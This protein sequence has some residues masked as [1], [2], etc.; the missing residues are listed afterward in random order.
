[1]YLIAKYTIRFRVILLLCYLS[2]FT[3]T[4]SA[5][6]MSRLD[7]LKYQ[8]AALSTHSKGDTNRINLM[9]EVAYEYHKTDPDSGI[10]Y[11]QDALVESEL[12]GWKKGMAMAGNRIGLCYWA[13]SDYPH[14]LEYH[15][16]ALKVAE[17][18]D[19]KQGIATI[20]GNIG[21]AY[22]GQRDYEKALDYHN[23]AMVINE[24]LGNKSGVARNL[25]NI[26]IVYDAKGDFK[27]A[28]KFYLNAMQEYELL[29]D[30]GGVARNLGNIG[31][32]YQS[33][34]M[35]AKALEYLFK[36]LEM[37][38]ELG[39][40]ILMG[41]NL[42]NIG[43]TYLNI[44]KDTSYS[45]KKL[46]PDSLLKHNVAEK[47]EM[48]LLQGIA[49][50]KEID[51]MNSMQELY[52]YLSELQA[53]TGNY[54]ESLSSYKIHSS[55]MNSLFNEENQRK[56]AQLEKNREEDIK[57]K[58]IE[59]LKSQNEVERLKT[60]RRSSI[61]YGLSAV[62]A[63]LGIFTISFFRQSNKRRL[64]NLE[65]QGAYS[66]LKDTQQQLVKSEKMAAFGLMAQRIA[67][68]IQNPLNFVN[69]FSEISNELVL[70]LTDA[71]DETSR[72][73]TAGILKENLDRIL[74]HGKRAETI[75]KEL[76]E[77]IRSGTAHQYFE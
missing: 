39:N 10:R 48:Y 53:L 7:S 9:V 55:Y 58:E 21:L 12:A 76:Q 50:F 23:R 73:E 17:S 60:Q 31:F 52:G 61:N 1:M 54:K 36:A 57:Q 15:F 43:G 67:H 11:G 22:E 68:E 26:G 35:H 30:K 46:L 34:N 14:S 65:L 56:I 70:E 40:K 6:S 13:K 28:L 20:L 74:H 25:G 62:L 63:L 5:Q 45:N 51:D 19:Y 27:N 24:Q 71:A 38:Q 49:I 72:M 44:L 4:V 41:M 69:N 47:S 2:G 42:G 18:I 16:R 64:I 75:V 3:V 37:N 66:D 33:Q 59:L 8:L 29:N 77:H 32:T